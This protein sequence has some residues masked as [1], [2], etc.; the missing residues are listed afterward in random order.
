[1]KWRVRDLHKTE[2]EKTSRPTM[3]RAVAAGVFWLLVAIY[4]LTYVGAFKSGDERIVFS[5]LD[6]WVKRGD[7]TINQIYWAEASRL[8]ADGEMVGYFEPGQMVAAA[9]FYA[10][11]R[12][13][14]AA[15]QGT[16]FLNVFVTAASGMLVFLCAIT[17]GYRRKTALAVAMLFGLAT[18]AWAYSRYFFR[19][20]LATFAGLLAFYALL[21]YGHERRL[22]WLALSLLGLGLAVA[23]KLS[24]GALLLPLIVLTF[25]YGVHLPRL[26]EHRFARGI[27]VAAVVVLAL[28]LF[29]SAMIFEDEGF[30]ALHRFASHIPSMLSATSDPGRILISAFGLTVSPYKGLF[31]YAPILILGLLAAPA[32]WKRHPREALAIVLLLSIYLIGHI[33]YPVWWGGLCWGPRF[34][35]P[36][37]PFLMLMSLPTIERAMRVV[38]PSGRAP[39]RDILFIA[40]LIAVVALSVLIQVVSVSIDPHISELRT[41][42]ELLQTLN[43]PNTRQIVE[44]MTF[45]W[46]VSPILGQARELLQFNTHLD[47]AWVR[48]QAD[49][50]TQV[51]WQ[52]LALWLLWV[53]LTLV[54]LWVLWQKPR[55][56]LLVGLVALPVFLGIA[57]IQLLQYREGDKRFDPYALAWSLAPIVEHLN[58][59]AHPDDIL[60]VNSAF[61]SDYFLNRLQ[62]SLKWYG[63]GDQEYPIR[64]DISAL[65][66]RILDQGRQIWLVRGQPKEVDEYR[67][68]ERYLIER[69]FKVDELQFENWS[70]LMLFLPPRGETICN[71]WPL[72]VQNDLV[73]LKSYAIRLEHSGQQGAAIESPRDAWLQ[74]SLKWEAVQ[75]MD[76]NYTT[77]VQLLDAGD[78]VVWQRDRYPGEGIVPTSQ[79]SPGQIVPDRFAFSIDLPPGSYRLIAGMY[80]LSSMERL[81]WWQQDAILLATLTVLDSPMESDATVLLA[82]ST[83]VAPHI[84]HSFL[85]TVSVGATD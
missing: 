74:L 70:R 12:L 81:T 73:K 24:A 8:R 21:R 28:L 49:V 54:G 43:D 47:F 32:F 60:I 77:F 80:N 83:D 14:G 40:A 85:P 69:A 53:V 37:I 11:G 38:Q 55:Q 84:R 4:A 29:L 48:E 17:L 41:I 45:N 62:A 61:Q 44:E 27:L 52:S 59:N 34:L 79:W 65:V 5:S 25:G 35:V 76:T 15:V 64:K 19:E 63:L 23:T 10:W 82:I 22:L 51:L 13:L 30:S 39:A 78:Q 71:A 56:A 1:M 26:R 20:P 7:L 36:I 46:N 75:S 9:P 50:G 67:G 42:D 31:I 66:D 57:S 72:M 2:Q 16:F 6:S 33:L 68:L 58:E 3:D 18:P